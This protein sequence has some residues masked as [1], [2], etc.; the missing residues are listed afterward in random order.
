MKAAKD[1]RPLGFSNSKAAVEETKLQNTPKGPD[2]H[3]VW[4]HIDDRLERGGSSC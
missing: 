2:W 3:D 1:I 4:A